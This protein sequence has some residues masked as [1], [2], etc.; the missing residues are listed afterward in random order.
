MVSVLFVCLG[1]ICRS[2]AAEGI[3]K[4]EKAR[5]AS[6]NITVASCGMG[7]HHKDWHFSRPAAQRTDATRCQQARFSASIAGATISRGVLFDEYDYILAA[8]N[9]VL[10]NLYQYAKS[11]HHKA[12][13]QSPDDHALQ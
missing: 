3:L 13:L 5:N 1:N 4:P 9:E 10:Q 6:R 7:P 11:P 8:D 2:P 12:I